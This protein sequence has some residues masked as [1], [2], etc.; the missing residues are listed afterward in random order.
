M[1]LQRPIE[2]TGIFGRNLGRN[3]DRKL[4]DLFAAGSADG[5]DNRRRAIQSSL[6]PSSTGV[7]SPVTR[8]A[9]SNRLRLERVDTRSTGHAQ[10]A[11]AAGLWRWIPWAG[12]E[13]VP[14]FLPLG[15]ACNSC[16]SIREY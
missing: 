1:M 7:A 3:R 4:R 8:R 6:S 9:R 11:L 5:R 15:L 16:D 12:S 13:L 10:E 2:P 14:D